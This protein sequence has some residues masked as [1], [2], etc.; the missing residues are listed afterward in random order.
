MPFRRSLIIN[1]ILLLTPPAV[2]IVTAAF[3]IYVYNDIQ[4]ADEQVTA[5]W[6]NVIN[7][8]QR[9]AD[10]VPNLVNAVKAYAQHEKQLLVDISE[11]RAAINTIHAQARVPKD[12]KT[13]EQYQLAQ[14]RMNDAVS[15]ILLVAENYPALRANGAFLD[16]QAQLE[17]TENRATYARIRYI[18]AVTRY[19]TLVRS[20]PNNLLARQFGYSAKPSFAVKDEQSIDRPPRVS[21]Q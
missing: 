11:A 16:L 10:L 14:M 6:A 12:P 2:L 19:N 21:L 5:D 3:F 7:Q 8:Y 20:F 1:V 15:H 9:R 17:G 13:F 18:R 4:D